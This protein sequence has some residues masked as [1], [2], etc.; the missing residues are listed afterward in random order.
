MAR[1]YGTNT[2][3]Y[4]SLSPEHV[5]DLE[6]AVCYTI[7][8]QYTAARSLFE[9]RLSSVKAIP[10][11]AIERAELAY[12]QGRYKEIWETLE[13]VLP[14]SP[15]EG[16]E[17]D[18]EDAPYRLM[19]ILHAL[20]A[21]RYKGTVEPAKREILRIRKWLADTPIESYTDV[22][23]SIIAKYSQTSY[24]VSIY[25]NNNEFD[26]A[27][28]P[29]SDVR[30]VPWQGLT[31]LRLSLLQR[32]MVFEALSIFKAERLRLPYNERIVA[33]SSFTT[34]LHA[35]RS[36]NCPQLL[37]V[38]L[39]LSFLLAMTHQELEDYSETK[40]ELSRTECL[41]DKWC[42][43]TQFAHKEGL[44]AFISIRYAQIQ[45]LD[46]NDHRSRYMQSLELLKDADASGHY[47]TSWCMFVAATAARQIAL[48]EDSP[49]MYQS[50]LDLH[51]REE[52]YEETVLGDLPDLL[53]GKYNVISEAGRNPVHLRKAVEWIDGFLEAYPSFSLPSLLHH[54]HK[55][56]LL[57][58][59]MLRE[60]EE[61]ARSNQVVESLKHLLPAFH[62]PLI[63]VRPA[64]SQSSCSARE[65]ETNNS[66][67]WEQP[68]IGSLQEENFWAPWQDTPLDH[69]KQC[70]TAMS[71]LLQWMIQDMQEGALSLADALEIFGKASQQ[72]IVDGPCPASLET[73][74]KR[75]VAF[76]SW[77]RTSSQSTVTSR[78]SLLL[79]LQDIRVWSLGHEVHFHDWV[80]T[81]CERALDMMEG[82][83]KPVTDYFSRYR[84]AY[85]SQIAHVCLN[86]CLS[87][88]EES[89]D[90]HRKYIEKAERYYMALLDGYLRED[91]S[92]AA[93][94]Q[95]GMAQVCLLK[96]YKAVP[97]GEDAALLAELRATGLGFLEKAD[98]CFDRTELEA[99]WSAG[100]EGFIGRQRIAKSHDPS[101]SAQVALNLIIEGNPNPD[102]F[103]RTMMWEWVQ[104]AKGQSLASTIGLSRTD[105]PSMVSNL[106]KSELLS[107]LYLR[108]CEMR[109]E[110]A[111]AKPCDR[112][113]LR[114]ELDRHVE[115][116]K[117]HD[118]LKRLLDAR[119]GKHLS[120]DDLKEMSEE[121]DTAVVFVDW[122]YLPGFS[123]GIRP[124]L[125]LFTRRAGSAPAVDRLT[126]TPEEVFSWI[127]KFIDKKEPLDESISSRPAFRDEAARTECVGKISSLVQP[128]QRRTELGDLLVLCPT[129]VLHRIPLHALN[130]QDIVDG[131]LTNT[132]LIH[133][134]PVVYMHSHSLLRP[135]FWA[136]K[137]VVELGTEI[138]PFFI[139][140]A[141]YY[142]GE[143]Q[144]NY[145]AG[146]E[147]MLSLSKQYSDTATLHSAEAT[148][149]NFL[150]NLRK[151]RMVHMQSH[152]GWDRSNPLEHCVTFPR[153][154]V[155][156]P[157]DKDSYVLTAREVFSL[158]D[159]L[160]LGTHLNLLV[161]SG[162]ATLMTS[163]DEPFGLIP[164][165]VYSGAASTVSTLW[166]MDDG[167]AA[168]FSKAFF[169]AL[170]K[171]CRKLGFRGSTAGTGKERG[172]WVNIA[173]VVQRTIKSLDKGGSASLDVWSGFVMH[174]FWMMWVGVDEGRRFCAKVPDK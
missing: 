146:H 97:R 59:L 6:H 105:P 16:T 70:R 164:A 34:G 143:L 31:D 108:L 172:R 8:G 154:A 65:S 54:L 77:L 120:P 109:S 161:C 3:L 69:A 117:K 162:A 58:L 28:I 91:L 71:F 2:S 78:Q 29:F 37:W 81:E 114:L 23:A 11:V 103:E 25:A 101:L 10:V 137:A 132:P 106:G 125:L 163:G 99:S 102:E 14:D 139:N 107:G 150:D 104:K 115:E 68:Q 42:E 153:L 133:R 51:K 4:A 89:M 5:D 123:R 82:L 140:G 90:G 129:D 75:V 39:E 138:K 12:R 63:G 94:C 174:G 48:V 130:I 27:L 149:A 17:P 112:Y 126:T 85:Q 13:E 100:L 136:S 40:E 50:F 36:L 142:K 156:V 84:L 147:M 113:H 21:I 152:C 64:V 165:L 62:G 144:Q 46:D 32:D 88:Q 79:M 72:A 169:I 20:A 22:Q 74:G 67:S 151:T 134:N 66:G 135:C 43:V 18:M 55:S 157:S 170:G 166:P 173:K 168:Q 45:L 86:L 49:E 92:S 87:S 38:E 145:K 83:H 167:Y 127:T 41:L 57:F 98:E 116:M 52:V 121:T 76:T 128:L 24:F 73:W 56:R 60:P 131:E 80:V 111:K 44:G 19:R 110:I 160:Q 155:D 122:F 148:K 93:L 1:F 159:T 61:A 95:R 15:S 33:I 30:N 141:S 96:L 119:E 47:R 9:S 53:L 158:Q 26:A 35:C 7:T 171:E 118:P 124:C